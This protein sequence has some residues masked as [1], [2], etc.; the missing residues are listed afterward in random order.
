MG[1]E[2]GIGLVLAVAKLLCLS[3]IIYYPIV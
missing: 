3:I 2:Q 1:T